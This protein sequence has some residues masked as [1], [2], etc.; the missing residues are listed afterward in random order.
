MAKLRTLAAEKQ[1]VRSRTEE[2]LSLRSAETLGRMIGTL[3]RQLDHVMRRVH[4]NGVNVD[5]AGSPPADGTSRAPRKKAAS[6]RRATAKEP[7]VPSGRTAASRSTR[8]VPST[9]AARAARDGT[10][11]AAKRVSRPK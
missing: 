9:R 10:V 6:R 7:P 5:G 4:D 11:K 8:A 3:Q 2:S 1:P